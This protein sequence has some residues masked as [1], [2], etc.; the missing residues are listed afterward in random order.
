MDGTSKYINL[1]TGPEGV[2]LPPGDE[3]GDILQWDGSYWAPVLLAIGAPATYHVVASGSVSDVVPSGRKLTHVTLVNNESF[4]LTVSLG[5]TNHGTELLDSEVIPSHKWIDIPISRY[6][7]FTSASPL[8]L[9][10]NETMTS[11]G[12]SMIVEI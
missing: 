10:I 11:S 12:L 5:L 9:Q 3:V 1:R 7:S 6:L 4:S 2:G 8:W